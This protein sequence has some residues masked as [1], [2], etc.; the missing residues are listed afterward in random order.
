M[1]NGRLF[2]WNALV[3]LVAAVVCVFEKNN[4]GV[5]V[6]FLISNLWLIAGYNQNG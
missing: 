6:S 5:W 4:T 3:W 1:R 2:T